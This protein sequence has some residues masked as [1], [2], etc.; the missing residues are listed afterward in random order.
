[1]STPENWAWKPPTE[2]GFSPPDGAASDQPSQPWDQPG[3]TGASPWSA[4]SWSSRPPEGGQPAFGAYGTPPPGQYGTPPGQT[5]QYPGQFGAGQPGQYGPAAG[6]YGPAA[7]AGFVLAPKPGIIPLRPLGLGEILEGAFQA[8]RVNPR[9]MFLPSLLVNTVI[10]ALAALAAFLLSQVS[11]SSSSDDLGVDS[12]VVISQYGGTLVTVLLGILATAI[13]TGLLIVAVSRAVLGRLATPSETWERTKGRVWALIG[14]TVLVQLVT[15]VMTAVMA[16]L[17]VGIVVGIRTSTDFDS[18]ASIIVAVLAVLVVVVVAFVLA[19][20]VGVKMS[21]APAALVLENLSV[22]ESMKRS[23]SLTRGFFWR[24]LGIM[25]LAQ[26]IVGIIAGMVGNILGIV[27]AVALASAPGAW[28]VVVAVGAF[29]ISLLQAVTVPFTAAVTA[30]LYIDTRMRKEGL[31]V[32]L[33]R[34]AEA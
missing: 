28:G 14:E 18:A 27:Q 34:A 5:G 17:A 7:P 8:L 1:M 20:F 16:L 10:G 33:R 25:L 2:D 23:W 32:E 6:Q 12:E 13:L 19:T 4:G 26:I 31:D 30:L 11:M 22:I 29:I 15:T 9:A 21:L 3:Q 24:I